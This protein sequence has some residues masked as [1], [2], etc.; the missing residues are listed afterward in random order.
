[1]FYPQLVAGPIER[2]QNMLHQF[3]EK[4]EFDYE[5]IRSGLGLMV[6]GLFKKMVI[7]DRLGIVVNQ[8]Y[9]NVHEYQGIPLLVA[10]LFFGFQIYCDFSGYSDIALGAARVMGFR[11]MVNFNFPFGTKNISDFWRHWH[12]SLSS[13]YNDY[14]YEPLVIAKRNWGKMGLLYAI[15][16]TYFISGIWHGAGWTFVIFGTLHGLAVIYEVLSRKKRKK[17]AKLLG[18]KIYNTASVIITFCY[19]CFTWVFFRSS[20]VNDAFYV[21]RHMFAG[22]GEQIHLIRIDTSQL[23]NFVYV[24]QGPGLFALS[25]FGIF[26]L[27]ILESIMRKKDIMLWI[28]NRPAFLRYSI[29]YG[30]TVFI[31]AFGVFSKAKFIYFQF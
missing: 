4:H 11:L 3:H 2:P 20:S 14:L 22:I 8:V 17:A 19:A 31:L 6:W 7:A 26:L 12:I 18:K 5:R 24:G 10:I 16:V 13:W 15:F 30:I 23:N 21:I 27:E 25:V 9:G 1:M 29:Y 28:F